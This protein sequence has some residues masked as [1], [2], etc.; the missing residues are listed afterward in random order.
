[1]VAV[2]ATVLVA[3]TAMPPLKGMVGQVYLHDGDYIDYNITGT[4]LIFPVKG[5]MRVDF[6]NVSSDGF[7]AAI[8][9][10]GIPGEGMVTNNYTWDDTIWTGFDFGSKVGTANVS[11]PW[12]LKAV[13]KYFNPNSSNGEIT[14]F[15]GTNPEVPYRVEVVGPAYAATIVMV[16]TNIDVVR[17]GNG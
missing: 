4:A 2:I 12:G 5:H 11:T 13:D 1:M 8:T 14:A 6:S 7:T 17:T 9:T 16:D 15:L 10:T 3:F